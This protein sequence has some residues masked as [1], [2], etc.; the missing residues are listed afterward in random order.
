[1]LITP[2]GRDWRL[3]RERELVVMDLETA[4]WTGV[5][6]P[7]SEW[8]LH[9]AVYR[10]RSDVAAVVHHHGPWASMVAVA[11]Q[12]IRVL[13]DEA[14]EIGEIPTAPYAPS[15]SLE[16]AEAAAEGLAGGRGAVLLANHGAVAVGRSLLE[17]VQVALEVE[18]LAKIFVGA[19]ALGGARALGAAEIAENR[20]FFK[21]Y[22]QVDCDRAD[23]L[24]SSP[25]IT[26]PV[27]LGDLIHF[28]LQAG[29][30][31]TALVWALVHQRLHR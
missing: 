14:A 20:E 12:T 17:A 16:L 13:I 27:R 30:T 4:A 5:S 2:S 1:M 26:G 29:V 31:M 10:R 18:R 6:Q 19:Q 7:S 23:A 15:G 8:R 25:P 3:L 9:L 28:G 24:Q 21:G 11:R 22:H